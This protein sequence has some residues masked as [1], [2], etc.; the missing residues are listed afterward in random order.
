VQPTR[1]RDPETRQ[2]NQTKKKEAAMRKLSQNSRKI[3]VDVRTFAE[4]LKK[5]KNL[6]L[7][8]RNFKEI[9]TDHTSLGALQ[10]FELCPSCQSPQKP[11][12]V[13]DNN[14]QPML[15]CASKILL[16]RKQWQE[17]ETTYVRCKTNPAKLL[18][19]SRACHVIA[20]TKAGNIQ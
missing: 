2:K 17:E 12:Q 8:S 16:S 19:A 13:L 9:C 3:N 20:A 10:L 11:K 14:N 15:S 6:L 4:S 7:R 1:T 5:C 18:M